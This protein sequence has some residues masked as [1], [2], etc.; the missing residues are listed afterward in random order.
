MGG[1]VQT[2]IKVHVILARDH[3]GKRDRE[4]RGDKI[5]DEMGTG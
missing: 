1:R 4:R 3:Q 5:R 2:Y